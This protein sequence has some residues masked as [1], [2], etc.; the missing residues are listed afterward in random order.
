MPGGS[1]TLTIIVRLRDIASRGISKINRGM[2]GMRTAIGG[3]VSAAFSLKGALAAIGATAL[4]RSFLQAATNAEQL[5]VRL[6]ILLGSQAEGARLFKEMTDYAARV[7]FTYGQIMTSAT[8]L[9]GVM[10]DGVDEVTKWI[11]LVGDLAAAS[12]LS[13]QQTTEQVIRMYS[14]GA[15]SAD[16]FRERG[17]NAML[18]FQAGVSYSAEETRK[19]LFEAW[20]DPA[21]QFRGATDQLAG[22][23]T[24][25]LSMMSDAWLAFRNM[26]MEAG[27]FDLLKQYLRTI[28]EAVKEL[29]ESGDLQRWAENLSKYII[30][31]FGI[32]AKAVGIV[33]DAYRGW[34]MIID[35]LIIA[36]GNLVIY[37]NNAILELAQGVEFLV[38]LM[39]NKIRA[40]AN[41]ME[42]VGLESMS[43]GI[44]E[45]AS[46]MDNIVEK[47]AD[48]KK[49]V[50]DSVGTWKGIVKEADAHLRQTA[51]QE[52]YYK[53]AVRLQ[54][55]LEQKAEEA[56]ANRKK[57][58]AKQASPLQRQ[59]PT[60]STL[61]KLQGDLAIYKAKAENTLL[62][63]EAG[64]KKGTA[65]VAEIAELYNTRAR[66]VQET[67]QK[68]EAVI[69]EQIKLQSTIPDKVAALQAKRVVLAEKFQG[70]MFKLTK[71]RVAAELDAEQGKLD[72]QRLLNDLRI[73]ELT[74]T[75][76]EGGLASMF[77][78]EMLEMDQRFAEEIAR[79]KQH[80]EE[81]ATIEEAYRVQKLEKERLLADQQFRLQQQVLNTLGSTLGDLADGF[82]SLYEESG[83]NIK[84][85]FYVF[86][87]ASIAQA[88]IST[89]ASAVEAYKATIGIPVFGTFL[90][91]AAASAAILAGMARVAAIRAQDFAE[92]GLIPGYSPNKKS[93]NILINATAR[94]FM[95]PVDAVDYYGVG[96]MEAIRKKM[97][98]RDILRSFA[99]PAMA[100]VPRRSYA[101]GGSVGGTPST[102]NE[103]QGFELKIFNFQ[104]RQELLAAMAGED[105]G[106]VILNHI[107]N[108]KERVTR[109][110]R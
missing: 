90:A 76:T 106:E 31:A 49:N 85:Y 83:K 69:L 66:I 14:A 88:I 74:A 9:A 19:K 91:P 3:V 6:N 21:S 57:E 16:L 33:I 86:K 59:A 75:S 110:I 23:W 65:S 4:A 40:L 45:I 43:A 96:A 108:N 87:A 68:E 36:Y 99:T 61:A 28:V 39:S 100:S 109:I 24:G 22:T 41:L 67:F 50:D 47:T 7:P 15:Q 55:T 64:V 32:I 62:E 11:P 12:G 27:V 54:E 94:E 93:D 34:E 51:K 80:E 2:K 58:E 103:G 26:V 42:S 97:V 38:D 82:E 8:A 71:D 95:Q 20:N 70:Q 63:L 10:K 81:K 89:Y 5:R 107:S 56:R 77:T 17:I 52:S 25:M 73:R 60:A 29:R 102:A 84:E 53:R 46:G 98:P 44:Q 35:V 48:F 30:K 101:T 72:H 92:G 104:D 78:K 105:A 1:E 79:L 13:I 18:G 37:S